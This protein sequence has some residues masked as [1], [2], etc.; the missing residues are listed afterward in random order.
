LLLSI[1]AAVLVPLVGLGI[2]WLIPPTPGVTLENFRRLRKGMTLDQAQAVL[3]EPSYP[4]RDGIVWDADDDISI[5]LHLD[6][7]NL[8]CSGSYTYLNAVHQFE[9]EW[10]VGGIWERLCHWLK[11]C[12]W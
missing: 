4:I 12:G 3:G 2:Y 5:I 9:R 6:D 1:V 8:V 10:L 11:D 7:N